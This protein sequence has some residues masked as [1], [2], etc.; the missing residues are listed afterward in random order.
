[1]F[2]LGFDSLSKG[3]SS[4]VITP[5]HNAALKGLIPAYQ[6]GLW[7]NRFVNYKHLHFADFFYRIIILDMLARL[8]EVSF[9]LADPIRIDMKASLCLPM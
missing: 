9:L 2:G 7:L 1:M 6:F 4:G 5:I 8:L 3:A